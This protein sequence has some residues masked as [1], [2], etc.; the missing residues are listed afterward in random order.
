MR[1]VVD[2]FSILLSDRLLDV[3]HIIAITKEFWDRLKAKYMR[4]NA[5]N[6]KFSTV[7]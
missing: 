1:F 6:N 3:Y 2:I 5:T 4:E 7:K